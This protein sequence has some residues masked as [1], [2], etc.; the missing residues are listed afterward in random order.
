M[1]YAKESIFTTLIFDTIFSVG[2]L[3]V[4]NYALAANICFIFYTCWYQLRTKLKS[5][6]R[7]YIA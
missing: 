2:K 6:T 5:S 3:A 1:R 4:I 7:L